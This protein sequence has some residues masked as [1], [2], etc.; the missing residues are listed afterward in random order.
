[1]ASADTV[2]QNANR[3]TGNERNVCTTGGAFTP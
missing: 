3:F 1:V 2:G